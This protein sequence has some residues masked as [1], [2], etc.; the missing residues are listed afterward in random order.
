MYPLI[1]GV[2]QENRKET[3]GSLLGR[4]ETVRQAAKPNVTR[5]PIFPFVAHVTWQGVPVKGLQDPPPN[6]R[7]HVNWWEGNLVFLWEGRVLSDVFPTRQGLEEHFQAGS[8]RET[9][10][11]RLWKEGKRQ[12]SDGRNPIR[13]ILV[14]TMTFVGSYRGKSNHSMGAGFRPSTVSNEK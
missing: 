5:F 9:Q 6:G 1:S 14:E 11:P 3:K 12:P 8:R 13:T 2:T 7:F 10:H 4:S